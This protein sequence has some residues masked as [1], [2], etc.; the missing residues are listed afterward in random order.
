[1]TRCQHRDQQ[2]GERQR[3]RR[4]EATGRTPDGAIHDEPAGRH[5]APAP[6]AR[7]AWLC[8]LP[9]EPEAPSG[10]RQLGSEPEIH[11]PG[12]RDIVA[13]FERHQ[14]REHAGRDAAQP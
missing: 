8:A 12:R 9:G 5:A 6:P 14:H 13:Q 7:V 11:D 2:R 3:G 4:R 1:M 10:H